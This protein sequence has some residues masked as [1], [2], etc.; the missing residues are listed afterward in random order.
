MRKLTSERCRFG[1]KCS[2]FHSKKGVSKI[3][4]KIGG[5]SKKNDTLEFSETK[6]IPKSIFLE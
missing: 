1:L 6:T 3:V 4:S 2:I 5:V